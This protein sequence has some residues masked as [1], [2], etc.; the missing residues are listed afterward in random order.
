[1]GGVEGAEGGVVEL[2]DRLG[3]GSVFPTRGRSGSFRTNRT[4]KGGL[5][6]S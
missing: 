6:S 5:I 4:K 1:M 2:D 3:E